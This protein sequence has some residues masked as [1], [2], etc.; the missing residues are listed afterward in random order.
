MRAD[1]AAIGLITDERLAITTTHGLGEAL[2]GATFAVQE[3]T[4]GRVARNGQPWTTSDARVERAGD[5]VMVCT[6]ARGLV[7]D[8]AASARGAHWRDDALRRA[9]RAQIT[10]REVAHVEAMADLLS[11]ALANAELVETLRKTE[12]R[13]RTLFRAAPDAVL[14]VL[15]S[16]RIRE[17]NDAVQDLVG[18][19]AGAARR[20]NARGSRAPRGSLASR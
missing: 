13:F 2:A 1:G 17:A 12:W 11:V 4:L 15:Q 7:V 18:T 20:P 5:D 14:T 10:E 9:S 6:E 19:A 3:S 8:P 16:G